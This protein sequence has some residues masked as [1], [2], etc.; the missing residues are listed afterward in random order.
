MS[1]SDLTSHDV[2]VVIPAYNAGP[3][4]DA[5]IESIVTQDSPPDEI[6]VVDDGSSDDTAKRCAEW[7]D[8]VHLIRQARHGVGRARNVGVDTATG[9]LLAFLDADDLWMP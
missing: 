6:I 9:R 4:I 2:S 8:R 5:A 1:N 3:F 7:G